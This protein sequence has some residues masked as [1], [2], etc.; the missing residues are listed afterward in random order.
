M[1]YKKFMMP[2]ICLSKAAWEIG[3]LPQRKPEK[4][5]LFIRKLFA[6]WRVEEYLDVHIEKE[7]DRRTRVHVLLGHIWRRPPQ[8]RETSWRGSK[9]KYYNAVYW[10][11]SRR[12]LA[13]AL[14]THR[15][16]CQIEQYVPL[17]LTDSL[18]HKKIETGD[19]AEYWAG[20]PTLPRKIEWLNR[21]CN[22][23]SSEEGS[24]SNPIIFRSRLSEVGTPKYPINFGW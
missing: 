22:L 14:I 21:H 20:T 8:D 5:I 7:M 18:R 23:L 4:Q 9:F 11:V 24:V 6:K 13:K 16:R 2:W 10:E 3:G 17:L 15:Y 1:P 19:L 12:Q